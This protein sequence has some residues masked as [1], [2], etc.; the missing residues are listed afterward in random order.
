MPS[1]QMQKQYSLME[2][3]II[4]HP[5]RQPIHLFVQ[6]NKQLWR[7]SRTFL[8]FFLS[9]LFIGILALPALPALA[10]VETVDEFADY[11]DADGSK[12]TKSYCTQKVL[13][14][15]PTRLISVGY[16]AQLPFTL[17][18]KVHVDGAEKGLEPATDEKV[19]QF[20]GLRLSTN[21][22]IISRSN[23][24]VNLGLNFWNTY[25][26]IAPATSG[27]FARSTTASRL[28]DGRGMRT[29]GVQ[30]TIFKPFDAK[31]FLIIQAQA[32]LSGNYLKVNQISSKNLTIAGSA[33]FGWKKSDNLLYGFGVSRTYRAGEAIIVPVVLLNRTFNPHWGIELALPAKGMVRYN[34]SP[35]SMLLAGYEIEGNTF[36]LGG[37][38]AGRKEWLRRG[39]VKPRI[40]LEQRLSGFVWLSVQAGLRYAY[41]LELWDTKNPSKTDEILWSHKAGLPF[42]AN[43]A[44]NL[45]SP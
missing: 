11:G 35:S 33:I 38:S 30:T 9:I 25:S 26:K 43:I 45:V 28:N 14:M 40:A 6:T 39:E 37:D 13:Y 18:S 44:I 12:P 42:Y 23:L 10:Q 29:M 1:Q 5:S 15:T 2:G 31:H 17:Q 20:R 24:I 21:T 22:P 8:A 36:Y 4:T 34:F 7:V 3:V 41:R 16:E 27:M 32:D 19:S